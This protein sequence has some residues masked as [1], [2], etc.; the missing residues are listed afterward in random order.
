[1]ALLVLALNLVALF[2][3]K[4]KGIA[5][6]FFGTVALVALMVLLGARRMSLAPQEVP[7]TIAGTALAVV[8]IWIGQWKGL[9]VWVV[10]TVVLVVASAAGML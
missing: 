7:I 1:M 2:I 9:I 4:G 5:V 10:G 6:W 8:S 3:G